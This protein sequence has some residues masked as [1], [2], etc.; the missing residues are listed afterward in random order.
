[1]PFHSHRQTNAVVRAGFKQLPA[2][3]NSSPP[4]QTRK[5]RRAEITSPIGFNASQPELHCFPSA[6]RPPSKNNIGKWKLKLKPFKKRHAYR[7]SDPSS[8][9][10]RDR[11]TGA[12]AR[13]SSSLCSAAIAF[14]SPARYAGGAPGGAVPKGDHASSS[15]S[16]SWPHLSLAF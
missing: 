16:G 6:A 2:Y 10:Y 12:C 8:S 13:G 5:L 3:I 9:K 11:R 14:A 4:Y 7:L 1:M 15:S